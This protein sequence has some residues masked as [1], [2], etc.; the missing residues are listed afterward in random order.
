[1]QRIPATERPDLARIAEEHGFEFDPEEGVVGWDES[2]WYQF[3]PRQMEDDLTGPMEEIE[4]LCFEVVDRAVT[5]ESVLQRLGIPEF[6]WDYIAQSWR[7]GEKNDLESGLHHLAHA[8]C[9]LLF[10]LW[11]DDR[12]VK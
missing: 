12:G 6:F 11:L 1:M 2:A 5:N 8:G 9:C 7:D 4:R 3:T 10:M